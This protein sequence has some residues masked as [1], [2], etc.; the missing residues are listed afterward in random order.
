MFRRSDFLEFFKEHTSRA[1]RNAPWDPYSGFPTRFFEYSPLYPNPFKFSCEACFR[2]CIGQE[3]G[4]PIVD[5]R[6]EPRRMTARRLPYSPNAI[7]P[8]P[9][10]EDTELGVLMELEVDHGETEV[11][12]G[13]QA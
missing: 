11:Y 7:W 13:V 12:A 5:N 2:R 1:G 6:S 4:N 9:G 3:S 10:S 8:A